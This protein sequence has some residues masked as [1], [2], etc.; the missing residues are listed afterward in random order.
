[1]DNNTS[2]FWF[3]RDLRLHDN[4]G[5][6]KALSTSNKVLAI[7]I[8]DTNILDDLIDDDRRVTLIY[9]RLQE[10]NEQLKPVES[11]INIYYGKPQDVLLNLFSE[12]KIDKVFTNTDY[13]P[14]ANKRDLLIAKKCKSLGIKFQSFKD[15]L[16]FEKDDILSDA[17]K[18]YAVY[19]PFMK[20]WMSKFR[21]SLT[22]PFLS[23]D[24]LSKLTIDDKINQIN[25]LK[26]MG[27]I[28]QKVN[29]PEPKLDHKTL[30]FYDQNKDFIGKDGTTRISVH[31]RFG[32]LSVREVAKSAY[33]YSEKLLKE[34]IWRSFFSQILWH[35][36][37]VV[38][39]CF[40]EKYE[41]IEWIN[42]KNQFKKWKYGK[43]GYPLVDA[44]MREL[45]DTGLMNNRVRMLTASFLVKNLGVDWRLG[46]A[47]F[48]SKLLDYDL[49]SNNGNWQW[50]AGTGAD[51][52]PY[53]RVF[54]PI[55]QQKK[56]DPNF[57]YCN[58]WLDEIN[59]FGFYPID[60]ITD[61]KNSRL[62]AIKRYK[63]INS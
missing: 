55:T 7:F 61:L 63:V 43:T 54:N 50:I 59:D 40:R 33:Q 37:Q 44:G 4:H 6:F 16:I 47:Y 42:D 36:P 56:F 15:H 62:D 38:D 14:Y 57:E 39:T 34:L 35:N 11:K 24:Y 5:L 29:I 58:R 28:H 22:A 23:Q 18:P 49:A 10:L 12:Y 21:I 3:R 27:F 60:K 31:L 26:E 32:F 45:F 46:E 48:A 2:V 52:A 19:N 41:Q 13:E 20:K 8:F 25:S 51:A 9:D 53:F 17:N 30:R 1:M